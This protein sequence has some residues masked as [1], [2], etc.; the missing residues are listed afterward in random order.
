M[1][2]PAELWLGFWIVALVASGVIFAVIT[3]LVAVRGGAEV[4]RMFRRVR[5]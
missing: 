1:P 3:V 2:R 5:K 4:I